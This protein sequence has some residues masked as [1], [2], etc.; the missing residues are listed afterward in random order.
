MMAFRWIEKPTSR[1]QTIYPR[2]AT[3]E[4]TA[5]GTTDAQFVRTYA[6]QA[7]SVIYDGLYRQDIKIDAVASDHWSVT[8]PYSWK[9]LVNYDLEFDTTGGTIHVMASR[10]TTGAFGGGAAVGDYKGMI[11]VHGDQVDGADVVIPALKLTVKFQYEIGIINLERIKTFAR[12]TAKV[13]TDAWLTFQPG[14]VLFL[15]AT[16]AQGTATPTNIA[17][18]FACSEN[19]ENLTIGQVANVKKKGHEYVWIRYK[20]EVVAGAA[21]MQAQSVYVERLYEPTAFQSLFGF[22]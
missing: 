22:G 3:L 7:T 9:N 8:V 2:T 13:N 18:H 14:E 20:P 4:F 19:A 17:F 1:S 15:G 16:G 10:E 21:V 5:T 12:N 11:G 6:L